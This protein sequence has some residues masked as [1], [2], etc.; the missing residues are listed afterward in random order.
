MR[1][2]FFIFSLLTLL[3]A[4]SSLQAGTLPDGFIDITAAIPDATLDIRYYGTE[5]FVGRPIDGYEAPRCILTTSAAQALANVQDQLAP[6]GLGIKVFDCYRPTLAVAHFVRWAADLEDTLRKAEYYP[7][8]DKENLFELGYIAERSGHSRG[9]TVDLTL[10]DKAT[11]VELDMG[12]GF[13]M[14][15]TFSW[16][17]EPSLTA[18]QRANRML[19]QTIMVANGFKPYDQEWW[20]FTLVDEPFPETYFDFPITAA[21]L[22]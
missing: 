16:P 17:T 20:H 9:S 13:D 2:Y 22:I 5:N 3:F 6:F 8:V 19:L 14:F 11:G 10:I 1:K 21:P 12:T 18:Q 4:A 7:D 15:S